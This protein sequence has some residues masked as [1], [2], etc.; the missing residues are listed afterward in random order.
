MRTIDKQHSRQSR[1]QGDVQM[2]EGQN[3]AGQGPAQDSPLAW[4]EPAAAQT[5]GG[6]KLARTPIGLE[7][8]PH[9]TIA[10]VDVCN[11]TQLPLPSA[12]RYM[13]YVF[14]VSPRPT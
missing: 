8:G 11:D 2:E 4:T 1:L 13:M 5:M 7:A 14:G 9:S 10:G 3:G 12:W 6:L